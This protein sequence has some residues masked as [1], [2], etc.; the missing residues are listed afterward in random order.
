MKYTYLFTFI[1]SI[2]FSQFLHSKESINFA[3]LPLKKGLRNIEE[4]LPV[5][6]YLKDKLEIKIN[7]VYK[8]DY[9]DIIKGFEDG[10]IDITYLGSLPY[11]YLI[12]KYKF[13]KPIVGFKEKDGKNEYRC[14]LAKFAEDKLDISKPI[15]VALTQPLSTCGYY[16][17]NILLKDNFNIDLSKQ[18][19]EYTMSHSNALIKIVEGKFLIAGAKESIARKYESLGV[20]IIAI[21]SP[22]N[23]FYLI[24]NTKTLSEE[25]IDE[26]KK[27]LLSIPK[28]LYQSWSGVISNGMF[29]LSIKESST[30]KIDFN[31]IPKKGNL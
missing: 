27:T 3:P 30:I 18:K 20:E 8:Q 26:I 21:S 28:E 4:F 16:M 29:E 14:V 19:Y 11:T 13:I 2:I 17:T 7:Y 10:S 6:K 23:N 9:A 5:S 22:L 15:K 31:R 1:I 25:K 24:A 12:Q